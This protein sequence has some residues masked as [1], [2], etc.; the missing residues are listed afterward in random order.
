[1]KEGEK[2]FGAT[3]GRRIQGMDVCERRRNFCWFL[4]I[5]SLLVEPL[6]F[7]GAGYVFRFHPPLL[8]PWFPRQNTPSLF[9]DPAA[10]NS[11]RS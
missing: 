11:S 2:M 7:S 3:D 4:L 5:G 6:S 1:M 9:R 8:A 10:T